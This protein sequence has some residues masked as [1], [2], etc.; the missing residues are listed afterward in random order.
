[1][2]AAGYAPA[3]GE[4]TLEDPELRSVLD[5][6]KRILDGHLPYPAV[7]VN[8]HGELVSANGAFWA[9]TPELS[10]ELA[11]APISVPRLLLHPQGWAP[12]ILNLDVWSWHVIDA[13][14]REATRN[15]NERIHALVAELKG[16]VP[17][18]PA[19]T[20]PAYRGFA[21]PMR[22][23]LGE[24]EL[25]LITTLTHFGTAADVEIS[26][27]RLEAF[28]PGDASTSDALTELAASHLRS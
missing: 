2:L 4:S 6:V 20:A 19:A 21:V 16:L 11:R 12:N 27:L 17:D 24:A 15:P 18:R 1:L 10:D 28:L 7:V 5:A 8:R 3:Y 9:L 23:R 13:L 14:N 26:E 25:E 22:L